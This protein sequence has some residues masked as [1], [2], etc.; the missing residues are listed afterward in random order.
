MTLSSHDVRAVLLQQ[1]VCQ[2]LT[3]HS[4]CMG[5]ANRLKAEFFKQRTYSNLRKQSMAATRLELRELEASSTQLIEPSCK[6]RKR[7]EEPCIL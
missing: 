6:G 4:V 3:S 1:A 2:N 7:A 5:L